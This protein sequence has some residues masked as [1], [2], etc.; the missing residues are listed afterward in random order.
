MK[1]IFF[2]IVIL[3]CFYCC[4]AKSNDN[5]SSDY[6]QDIKDIIQN[7]SNSRFNDTC[8]YYADH[9]G[10]I[11]TGEHIITLDGNAN[12][13][14]KNSNINL[15]AEKM[16]INF[17]KGIVEANKNGNGKY[18]LFGRRVR[19]DLTDK[20][21]FADELKYCYDSLIGIAKNVLFV[22]N[23]IIMRARKLKKHFNDR[24][25]IK[26]ALLTTC[27]HRHPKWGFFIEK[28]TYYKDLIIA[29]K[30]RFMFGDKIF[31]IPFPFIYKIPVKKQSGFVYPTS[32][33]YDSNYGFTVDPGFYWYINE[34]A[35]VLVRFQ[36]WTS[37]NIKIDLK[38]NYY[39]KNEHNSKLE[40]NLNSNLEYFYYYILPNENPTYNNSFN[41]TYHYDTLQSKIYTFKSD[42]N[43]LYSDA[44]Q[45]EKYQQAHVGLYHN[46]VPFLCFNGISLFNIYNKN[47]KTGEEGFDVIDL[48][49]PIKDITL[50][51]LK[52]GSSLQY[53]MSSSNKECDYILTDE[54]DELYKNTS[55]NIAGKYN[56]GYP[57]DLYDR[58]YEEEEDDDGEEK[59]GINKDKLSSKNWK[60]Y[61]TK[62]YWSNVW[63]NLQTGLYVPIDISSETIK[64]KDFLELNLFAKYDMK[65]YTSILEDKDNNGKYLPKFI[66]ADGNYSPYLLHMF[67]LG[68]NAKLKKSI[69]ISKN[70][71]DNVL[72]LSF[73]YNP[74]S[75]DMQADNL[76]AKL[77]KKIPFLRLEKAYVENNTG[78][79]VD[80]FAHT[81]FGN[82]TKSSQLV[83]AWNWNCN[84]FNF[85][86]FNVSSGCDFF[87]NYKDTFPLKN[88][89]IKF[90]LAGYDIYEVTLNPYKYEKIDKSENININNNIINNNNDNINNNEINDNIPE[91]NN[92]IDNLNNENIN[93]NNNNNNINNNN[94][95]INNNEINDNIP[96]NNNNINN[97]NNE[98]I[99]N[100]NNN[101]IPLSNKNKEVPK[102]KKTKDI[103]FSVLFQKLSFPFLSFSDISICKKYKLQMNSILEIIEKRNPVYDKSN[104]QGVIV[105]TLVGKI[106][107]STIL[108]CRMQ[109]DIMKSKYPKI[110][111]IIFAIVSQI[112]DCWKLTIQITLLNSNMTGSNFFIIKIQP[113]DQNINMLEK[114]FKSFLNDGKL[115]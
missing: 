98:N 2:L 55:M 113:N 110:K 54:N 22:S 38:N 1:H 34:C 85:V 28:G 83:L 19:L 39:V 65:L 5:K 93:I 31:P 115:Y 37:G 107:A 100:L 102:F 106:S 56:P 63:D 84:I 48:L 23:N 99:N 50:G 112:C 45:N 46:F 52:I 57:K 90:K 92:N 59:K 87:A 73:T 77:V 20:T 14:L 6:T 80:L 51:P 41:I 69:T 17:S 35:D 9:T 60:D 12:I 29:D 33:T 40:I 70:H 74:S 82:M 95:N 105:S 49:V 64:V 71:I 109:I 15:R 114:D 104:I 42:V 36:F 7:N 44:K 30:V 96:E 10:E 24:I 27:K 89:N 79:T 26:D 103:D 43:F 86:S 62:Q 3:N 81:I 68:V 78:K 101:A 66:Y 32:I 4:L 91:N 76:F 47:F 61:F 94:D 111:N 18:N 25:D 58:D 97:L 53:K 67:H 108:S 21:L 88:I 13:R 75:D 8:N 72:N 16:N 11:N